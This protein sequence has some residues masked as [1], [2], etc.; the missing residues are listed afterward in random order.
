MTE[1]Y[2]QEAAT[3]QRLVESDRKLVGQAE[4]LR[5]MVDQKSGTWLIENAATLE[6]GFVA[7]GQT[8]R[9]RQ[10]LLFPAS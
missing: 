7:I 4:L 3:L 9:N 2:R 5:S 1:R 8:L 6:E 10:L